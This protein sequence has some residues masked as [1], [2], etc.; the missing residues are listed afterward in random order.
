M[1]F[2]WYKKLK[3]ANNHKQDN[4]ILFIILLFGENCQKFFPVFLAMYVCGYKNMMYLLTYK[5]HFTFFHN[6]L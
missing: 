6:F 4:K 2:F 1:F 5:L 3:N